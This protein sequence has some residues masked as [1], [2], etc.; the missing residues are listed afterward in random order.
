MANKYKIA[1]LVIF[2][3]HASPSVLFYAKF[4]LDHAIQSI[5]YSAQ[6]TMAFSSVLCS[7]K[8]TSCLDIGL[9]QAIFIYVCS[10]SL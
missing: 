7:Q 1:Q 2:G 4:D 6:L 5:K 8:Q 3:T 10:Y 9:N